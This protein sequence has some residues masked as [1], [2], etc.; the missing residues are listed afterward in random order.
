MPNAPSI[1]P[2]ALTLAHVRA[3]VLS[4]IRRKWGLF[5]REELEALGSHAEVVAQVVAKY[6]LQE[7]LAHGEVTAL[8]RG[9]RLAPPAGA[10][11][12]R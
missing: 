10:P 9:R 5:S 3:T 8:L 4:D 7:P 1:N 2:D 11:E 6:G 12:R